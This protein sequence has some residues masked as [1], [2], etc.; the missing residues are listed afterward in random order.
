M[1]KEQ[2]FPKSQ[3]LIYIL[4]YPKYFKLLKYKIKFNI[5]PTH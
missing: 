2:T 1:T 3:I 4:R 5:S